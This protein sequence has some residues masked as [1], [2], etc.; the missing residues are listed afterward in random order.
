MIR[1]LCSRAAAWSTSSST[2]RAK[3][4]LTYLEVHGRHPD[5]GGLTSVDIRFTRGSVCRSRDGVTKS[6]RSPGRGWPG[7]PQGLQRLL[8]WLVDTSSIDD[9]TGYTCGIWRRR[10]RPSWCAVARSCATCLNYGGEWLL[11]Y[12]DV[13]GTGYCSFPGRNGAR[14]CCQRSRW[15]GAKALTSSPFSVLSMSRVLSRL[16]FLMLRLFQIER[17]NLTFKMWMSPPLRAN[18]GIDVRGDGEPLSLPRC[19]LW[20]YVRR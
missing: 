8:S 3:T 14:S 16:A 5:E 19:F 4:T 15:M 9:V 6:S 2:P 17:A 7:L 12:S 1:W 11:T 10:L 20:Q 13:V 18:P